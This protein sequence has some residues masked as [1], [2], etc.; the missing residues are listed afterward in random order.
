MFLRMI[1]LMIKTN[2][3]LE[4]SRAALFAH[5]TF[6]LED[7][8]NLFDVNS[9]GQ[10][11]VAEFTQVCRE[12]NM[13]I[14]DIPRLIDIIDT[15]GDGTITF[16]E[17]CAALKPKKPC[18]GADPANY[19]TLEQKNLFQRAWLEQLGDLFGILIQADID[20]TAKRNQL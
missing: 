18:R 7:S 9:N 1:K 4:D 12:H 17:W 10:L 6:S 20:V 3:L 13:V 2:R 15:T 14:S 19:L 16:Q 5:K 11:T 8:Y